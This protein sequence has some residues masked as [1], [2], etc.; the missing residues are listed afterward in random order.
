MLR[1]S[2]EILDTVCNHLGG[3]QPGETTK[4]K[5][6]TV[7]EVE[8]QGACSNAPMMAV[9]DDFY[10]NIETL[11]LSTQLTFLQ[12]DLT[13]ESTKKILD[14]FAS[15]KKP[16]AGPQS[17]RHTSEN[18]AGLTTLTSKVCRPVCNLS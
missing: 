2:Y 18:S 17:G 13:P 16:K 5:K 10:V 7:I 6:F 15:G 4:D 12:E 11:L 14:A 1:G 9:G 3:I 8:C